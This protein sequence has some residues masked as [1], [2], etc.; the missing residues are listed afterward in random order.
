MSQFF[1]AVSADKNNQTAIYGVGRTEAVALKDA[2]DWVDEGVEDGLVAE[3]CT[4][5]LYDYVRYNG[6]PGS[7]GYDKIRRLHC[8]TAEAEQNS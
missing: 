8:T 1:V 5:A 3:P 2:R 7:W 4:E 6:T